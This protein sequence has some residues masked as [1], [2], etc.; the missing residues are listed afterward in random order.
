MP[1]VT[2]RPTAFVFIIQF[3]SDQAPSSE[4]PMPF[5]PKKTKL[6]SVLFLQTAQSKYQP[7]GVGGTRSPPATPH[8]LQKPKWPLVGPKMADEV[9][10]G[11]PTN[12][13]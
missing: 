9:W 12:F 5:H 2:G 13:H 10:K 11:A 1:I 4:Q 3:I 7:S 6:Q 8:R